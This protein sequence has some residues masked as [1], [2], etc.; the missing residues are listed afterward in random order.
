VL[1]RGTPVWVAWRLT[2]ASL[3]VYLYRVPEAF[4]SVK[5]K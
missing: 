4:W 1:H 5:G 2:H 3:R